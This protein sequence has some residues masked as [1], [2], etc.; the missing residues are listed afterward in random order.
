MY[1][2]QLVMEIFNNL[3]NVEGDIV[4]WHLVNTSPTKVK[5]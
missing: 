2:I 3:F 1:D 4:D 5:S